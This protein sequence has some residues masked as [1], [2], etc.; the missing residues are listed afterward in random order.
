MKLII[1]EI[2]QTINGNIEKGIDTHQYNLFF[3]EIDIKQTQVEN[4]EQGQDICVYD[5]LDHFDFMR[6]IA[7]T[8]V[9]ITLKE[10]IENIST[11][12]YS[13]ESTKFEADKSGNKLKIFVSNT[14]GEK[15]NIYILV[16][17]KEQEQGEE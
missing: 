9:K 4:T 12:F 17:K 2:A 14:S 16:A 3:N 11:T 7:G 10:D 5:G 1:N 6:I 15:T 8:K 13:A